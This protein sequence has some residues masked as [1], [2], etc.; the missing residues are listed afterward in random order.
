M[1]FFRPTP[2]WLSPGRSTSLYL[3]ENELVISMHARHKRQP[4]ETWILWTISNLAGAAT[5]VVR[6]EGPPGL[7]QFGAYACLRRAYAEPTR[8]S[9]T[10]VHGKGHATVC[11]QTFQEYLILIVIVINSNNISLY[12]E[13]SENDYAIDC[14]HKNSTCPTQPTQSCL[15]LKI[16]NCL[17]EEPTTPPTLHCKTHSISLRNISC[18]SLFN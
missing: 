11:I 14:L 4:A 6:Q 10:C 3:P 16:N 2:S 17:H 15:R 5:R 9:L 1:D 7:D 12:W 8:K 13:T 18:S